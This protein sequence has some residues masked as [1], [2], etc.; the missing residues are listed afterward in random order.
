MQWKSMGY[1]M[2]A[3]AADDAICINGQQNAVA[4]SCH[5]VMNLQVPYTV[6][7]F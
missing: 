1:V 3:A 6:G 2:T 4:G 7:A 5:I